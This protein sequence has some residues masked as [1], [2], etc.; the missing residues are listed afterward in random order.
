MIG[1]ALVRA[2]CGRAL[3]AGALRFDAHVQVAHAPF[4]TELG[5]ET[6]RELAIAG[7]PHLLMRW[8]VRRIA[9]H[10]GATKQPLGE[11]VGEVLP[12][13]RWRGDDGVPIGGSNVIACT[14]A[15]TPSMVDRDP[16]WAG[17]CGMLVTANDLSAMGASPL[18]A[19]DAVGGRDAAHVGSVL[20]GIRD[21]SEA[22]E[23]PV[24][25][26]HTQLGVPGAL[27]MT[28]FGRTAAPIPGGGGRPGDALWVCADVAGGWRPGYHG[29]QWDSTS[30]RTRAELQP[31]LELV[32][33]SRPNA[34]KDASMAGIVGTV[35]MLA[36]ASGC[37][38]EIEIARIPRPE[39]ALMADWL[40]C[41]PGFAVVLSQAP[42][43]PAPRGGAAICAGVGSLSKSGGVRLRWPDD[44]VTT[45]IAT[46]AITGLGPATGGSP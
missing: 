8:P 45:V 27:T 13:D 38:A 34:A 23:L 41:F 3:D 4:F 39:Q 14:D 5:W 25:G 17:W 15:I 33:R 32:R 7:M 26:G 22:F 6:I 43:A 40:T 20:R 11:L 28:G 12:H 31:M 10:A 21:G 44:Q 46:D 36:E 30:E 18:G 37:G 9:D 42:G 16:R 24:L 35:A 19:L 29:R 1:A 2:A